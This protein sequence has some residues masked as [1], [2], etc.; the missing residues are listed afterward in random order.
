MT[1][2]MLRLDGAPDPA[3]ECCGHIWN[4]KAF[5]PF[6]LIIKAGEPPWQETIVSR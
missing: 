6:Q 5:G 3:V 1:P 4:L 2:F